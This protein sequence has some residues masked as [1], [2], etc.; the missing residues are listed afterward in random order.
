MTTHTTDIFVKLHVSAVRSGL[1]ADIGPERWQTLT[2][3][4]S[5]MDGSG[6]C[7]P[8]QSTIA[9]AL[10]ISRQNAN[11]RIKRLLAYRW[12]GRP[13]VTAQKIR[14][15][16]GHLRTVYEITEVSGWGVF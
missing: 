12:R 16:T 8:S 9:E 10:G 3:L 14:G 13:V 11:V 15:P 5:F 7:W 2:A 4:A 6:R 1:L